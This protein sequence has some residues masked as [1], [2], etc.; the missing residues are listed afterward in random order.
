M[1]SHVVV[2]DSLRPP[3]LQPTRFLC[4]WDF[5]GKN[6]R[7]GCP[8]LLQGIFPTQRLNPILLCLLHWQA[9]YLSLNHLENIKTILQ[10]KKK[11]KR[12]YPMWYLLT[13]NMP[14]FR[15][16]HIYVFIL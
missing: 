6:A 1:L 16:V 12:I 15:C 14:E 5:L 11:K 9:D 4:L 13:R 2:S 8:F 7:V 10:L 3:G